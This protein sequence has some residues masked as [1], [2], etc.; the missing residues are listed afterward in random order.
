MEKKLN[1][2]GTDDISTPHCFGEHFAKTSE[3]CKSCR[4]PVEVNGQIVLLK[5]VC[6]ARSSGEDDP[7]NLNR[8]SSSEVRDRLM[9]GKPVR[10]IW[11]EILNGSSQDTYGVDARTLLYSRLRYL[12]TEYGLDVPEL[13]K[14]KELTNDRSE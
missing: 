5:E 10:E 14:T 13:P 1:T 9:S 4:A 8:L 12:K 7:A 6:K 2:I 3:E 11:L